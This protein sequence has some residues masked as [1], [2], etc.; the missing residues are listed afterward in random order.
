MQMKWIWVASL[1][2]FIVVVVGR[3]M[4]GKQTEDE[5]AEFKAKYPTKDSCLS[6]AAERVAPCTSPNCYNGVWVFLDRCLESADG[7]KESFCGSVLNNQQDS[8]GRDVFETHCKP[9]TQ[10]ETE[11]VK[12]IER[13]SFYCSRII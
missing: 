4:F 7:N 8:L 13:T 10:Y 11:C 5:A 3:G 1:T 12:V 6:G 2:L 9:F